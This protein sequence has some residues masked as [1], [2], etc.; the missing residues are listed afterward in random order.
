MRCLYPI[1]LVII[2]LLNTSPTRAQQTSPASELVYVAVEKMPRFKAT[3][4]TTV[5][6]MKY[7]TGNM[8]YPVAALQSKATGKVYIGF[9]VNKEGTVEQVKVVKKSHWALDKEALRVVKEMPR[10]EVPGQQLGQPVSVS[11]T[12]PITFNMSIAT[13]AQVQAIMADRSQQAQATV[14]T[15]LTEAR[16]QLAADTAPGADTAPVFPADPLGA[17]NYISKH[18]Q[19]PLDARRGRKEGVVMVAFTVQAD[20]AVSGARVTKSL[21]PSLDAEVL[22]VVN[23]MPPWN[24]ATHDGKPVATPLGDIPITFR[25]R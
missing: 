1:L 13:P 24:P 7:L 17:I 25:L 3:D 16:A 23:S 15:Q 21:F 18:L 20:G 4:S 9:V 11:F 5:A 10:W 6:L 22:R 8:R 12:V 2:G 19:Y 14:A